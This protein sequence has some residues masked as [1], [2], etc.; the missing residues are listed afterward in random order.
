[1]PYARDN[2]WK[3]KGIYGEFENLIYTPQFQ[4]IVSLGKH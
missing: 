2:Y 4:M 1:L 3:T